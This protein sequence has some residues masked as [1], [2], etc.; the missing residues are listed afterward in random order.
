ML[1]MLSTCVHAASVISQLNDDRQKEIRMGLKMA[2]LDNFPY[3]FTLFLEQSVLAILTS[4]VVTAGGFIAGVQFFVNSPFLLIWILIWLT[5]TAAISLALIIAT[6]FHRPAINS[7]HH[8]PPV[9]S[10]SNAHF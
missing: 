7:P 1:L 6:L 9:S 4:L 5:L 3:L 10:T 8:F 2:G